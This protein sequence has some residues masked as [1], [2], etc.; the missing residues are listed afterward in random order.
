MKR[1]VLSASNI[2]VD[3][4][5]MRGTVR[6]RFR[7]P[8]NDIDIIIEGESSVVESL[9]KELGLQGRVGFIQPLSAR[10]VDGSELESKPAMGD[11]Q[12][13][14]DVHGGEEKLPGP[15]PDPSSIPAVV[16]RIGDL[17]IKSKI[18]E[19]DGPSRTEPQIE[20]IR[21]FLESIDEPEPLSNN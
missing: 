17:D 3:G 2:G 7:S 8:E 18:S 19:L 20:Y 9:R 14:S 4:M 13:F 1:D 11:D 12:D 16:R 5:Q 6:F 21:E 15:P 10:L